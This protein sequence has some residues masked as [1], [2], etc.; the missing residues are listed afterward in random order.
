MNITRFR[1]TLGLVAGLTAAIALLGACDSG[2]GGEGGGESEATATATATATTAPTPTPEPTATATVGSEGGGR[3]AAMS[4]QEYAEWCGKVSGQATEPLTWAEAAEEFKG[5][6]AEYRSVAPPSEI[7]EYHN[8]NAALV[9][10]IYQ[11]ANTQPRD[12]PFSPFDLFGVGF[13][14][15]GTLEDAEASLPPDVRVVLEEQGCIDPEGSGAGSDEASTW[16]LEEY[17]DPITDKKTLYYFLRSA[18]DSDYGHLVLRIDCA[19]S[20]QTLL[21]DVN[22]HQLSWYKGEPEEV[23]LRFGEGEPITEEWIWVEDNRAPDV[24]TEWMLEAPEAQQAAYVER[25]R[26]GER[27]VLRYL[28]SPDSGISEQTHIFHTEGLEALMSEAES[29]CG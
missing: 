28:G 16:T 18:G 15:S 22:I 7:E 1:M 23:I 26:S 24:L 8:A 6:H 29:A 19:D 20:S 10:A 4:V 14:M 3:D 13:L 21:T 11:F 27:F 17:Q 9:A 2:S 12:D 25:L 5:L